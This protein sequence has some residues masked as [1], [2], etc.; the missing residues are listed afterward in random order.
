MAIE[1][2]DLPHHVGDLVPAEQH[3]VSDVHELVLCNRRRDRRGKL[4]GHGESF[5]AFPC[6]QLSA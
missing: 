1:D 4:I 5:E 2:R 6:D 3:I